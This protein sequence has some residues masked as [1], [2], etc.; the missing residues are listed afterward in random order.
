MLPA[1]ALLIAGV[2]SL[3]YFI[4]NDMRD[5]LAPDAEDFMGKRVRNIQVM[6]QR[7]ERKDILDLLSDKPVILS[8]IY[9]RCPGSCSIITSKLA[10][11]VAEMEGLG[12]DFQVITFSFDPEDRPVDLSNFSDRWELDHAGWQVISA[13]RKN[14]DDLLASINFWYEKDAE[15]GEYNHSNNLVVLSAEG[16]IAQY[17]YGLGPNKFYLEKALEAAKE[18][19]FAL[20]MNERL[21]LYFFRHDA[22]QKTYYID[23]N[24]VLLIACGTLVSLALVVTVLLRFAGQRPTS[25]S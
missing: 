19:R 13:N 20:S 10:T 25:A 14:I 23:W 21:L 16:K 11:V 22:A 2:L 8:P 24:V 9:T 15:T 12:T 4:P 7:G 6:D 18:G 5:N 3:Q 1:T 17:V